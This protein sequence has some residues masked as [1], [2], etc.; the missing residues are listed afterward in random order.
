MTRNLYMS[1]MIKVIGS[2]RNQQRRNREDRDSIQFLWRVALNEI[3]KFTVWGRKIKYHKVKKRKYN[4]VR[5]KYSMEINIEKSTVMRIS[6][7]DQRKYY[8]QGLHE[9]DKD[10]NWQR[11]SSI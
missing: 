10:Q 1:Q 9:G 7:R 5:R 2:S 11:E 4:E 6:K 3:G 8:Y